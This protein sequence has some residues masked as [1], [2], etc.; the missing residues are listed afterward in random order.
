M[1]EYVDA[2]LFATVLSESGT[3]GRGGGALA[4]DVAGVVVLLLDP[5]S[6]AVMLETIGAHCISAHSPTE[7]LVA[8]P[9]VSQ[10]FGGEGAD[11][12]EMCLLTTPSCAGRLSLSRV[13]L[14]VGRLADGK[15]LGCE[16]RLRPVEASLRGSPGGVVLAELTKRE[17]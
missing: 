4:D 9:L 15:T 2:F 10:G 6:P 13:L 3:D 14:V 7:A 1:L 16:K 17:R 11:M 12:S 5:V 8:P